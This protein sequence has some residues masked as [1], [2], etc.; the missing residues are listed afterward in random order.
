MLKIVR[1]KLAEMTEFTEQGIEEMLRALAEEH[2]VGLGKVAQPVR[3]AITGTTVSPPIFD[4]VQLLGRKQTLKRIDN[5]VQKF[6][7]KS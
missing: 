7:D 1:G 3:V 6:A 2:K 4:S 5:T